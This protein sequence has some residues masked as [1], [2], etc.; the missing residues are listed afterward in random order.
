MLGCAFPLHEGR[1]FLVGHLIH[2]PAKQGQRTA[3]KRF[4]AQ[5]SPCTENRSDECYRRSRQRLPRIQPLD[6]PVLA[7]EEQQGRKLAVVAI[8]TGYP[9]KR[10]HPTNLLSCLCSAHP[11]TSSAERSSQ[12]SRWHRPGARRSELPSHRA[13]A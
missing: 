6:S 1:E 11:T 10:S 4:L 7:T 13:R 8:P 2:A 9:A 3:T 12:G 5:A